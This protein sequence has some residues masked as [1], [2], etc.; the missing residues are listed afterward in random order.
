M[1]NLVPL[2]C[3]NCYRTNGNYPLLAR[4]WPNGR[5]TY[6]RRHISVTIADLGTW[7]AVCVGPVAGKYAIAHGDTWR[8]LF[9]APSIGAFIS[10]VCL[11]FMYFPPKHPRGLSFKDAL[12]E[13][14][15][16]GAVLFILA[17]ILILVGIVYT[18]ILPSKS[19]KVRHKTTTSMHSVLTDPFRLSVYLFQGSLH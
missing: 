16:V 5:L 19:P 14:D 18:I 2:L 4:A 6:D 9:H 1:F 12:R 7:L 10:I 3:R 8:W 17:G 15:Y 13:L 11:Y